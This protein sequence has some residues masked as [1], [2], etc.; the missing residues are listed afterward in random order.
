MCSSP[1]GTG[2]PCFKDTGEQSLQAYT[3][4]IQ[5]RPASAAQSD[6]TALGHGRTSIFYLVFSDRIS[7]EPLSN[8]ADFGISGVSRA[9]EG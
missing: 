6:V 9:L 8:K 1:L 3:G 5:E 2:V 4:Y 7:T